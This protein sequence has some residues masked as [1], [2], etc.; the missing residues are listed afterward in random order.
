[1]ETTRKS[2]NRPMPR[3]A[4]S[5]P[6]P[7]TAAEL[8]ARPSTWRRQ[9]VRL[10]SSDSSR[11][12]YGHTAGPC[13]SLEGSWPLEVYRPERL[14]AAMAIHARLTDPDNVHA[15]FDSPGILATEGVIGR[16]RAFRATNP[17]GRYALNLAVAV[18]R[19]VA[20]RLMDAAVV[21]EK[22]NGRGGGTSSGS[23]SSGGDGVGGGCRLP[24][25]RNVR[26]SGRNW[27]TTTTTTNAMLDAKTGIPQPWLLEDHI[28][29][30]GTLE[31]DYASNFEPVL[32][33]G[34][35]GP[36]PMR[37]DVL[38]RLLLERGVAHRVSG[39]LMAEEA[40]GFP[41]AAPLTRYVHWREVS[42][43]YGSRQAGAENRVDF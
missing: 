33:P 19:L 7:M 8:Q 42:L 29:N 27:T 17:T 12:S 16:S 13:L 9:T 21:E 25:W 14:A 38:E 18:D 37:D 39:D 3:R 32:A 15:L 10:S 5:S 20:Q 23:G 2:S 41:R 40:C 36:E 34:A 22:K 31:F 30:H 1:M 6:S 24:C 43:V 28:P 35:T 26:V 11:C 4:R